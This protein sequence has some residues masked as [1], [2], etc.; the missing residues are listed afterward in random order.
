[1][2]TFMLAVALLSQ[3]QDTTVY[4]PAEVQERPQLLSAPASNYR[5]C[6]EDAGIRGVEGLEF[7]IDT[8]GHVEPASVS[9]VQSA[10]PILDSLATFS[11][12]GEVF[13]A[14]QKNGTAVRVRVQQPLRYG[15]DGPPVA[16]GDSGV[17][18]ASC[19]DHRPAP[20]H[21][22]PARLPDEAVE[23]G[24]TGTVVLSFRVDTAG[25]VVR[26]S[27]TKLSGSREFESAAAGML[28]NRE[29]TFE[30]GRLYGRSVATQVHMAFEFARG[31]CGGTEPRRA[32]GSDPD[33]IDA[34]VVK[35]CAH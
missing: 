14:A 30:P 1:M 35:A 31:D 24:D 33:A 25:H 17:F 29:T 20:V 10:D 34:M 13:R 11:A 22:S 26:T 7:V 18:A 8:A 3:A 9:V 6:L 19:L 5:R 12:R 32:P 15:T 28:E 23:H 2:I 4:D 27:V 16:Q 21:V